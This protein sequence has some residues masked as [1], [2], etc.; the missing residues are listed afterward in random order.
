MTTH[1]HQG[2][3]DELRNALNHFIQALDANENLE[4][5]AYWQ[6]KVD[7]KRRELETLDRI[8]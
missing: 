8:N 7:E 3:C 4:V 6:H 2:V 5:I 1:Y